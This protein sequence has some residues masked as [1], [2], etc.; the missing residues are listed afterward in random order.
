VRNKRKK[1]FARGSKVTALLVATSLASWAT[2]PHGWY[3][4]G[5][6][7]AEYETGVDAQTTQ[8]GHASAYVKA[9]KPAIDGFGTLM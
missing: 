6:K 2:A 7:P 9:K 4:A 8:A 1:A 3:L 5:S